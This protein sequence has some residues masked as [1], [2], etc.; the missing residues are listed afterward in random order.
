MRPHD[1]SLRKPGRVDA[2]GSLFATGGKEID[3]PKTPLDG[4]ACPDLYL[5]SNQHFKGTQ[6]IYLPA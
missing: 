4:V 3:Q 5:W 6:A 2:R 1:G